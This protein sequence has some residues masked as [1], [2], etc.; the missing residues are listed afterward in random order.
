MENKN[1]FYS[2]SFWSSPPA[3]FIGLGGI[4]NII[5]GICTLIAG[6]LF[7]INR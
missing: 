4:F 1:E 6:I 2:E 7:I 3:W 5:A